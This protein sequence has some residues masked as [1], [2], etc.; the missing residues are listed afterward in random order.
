MGFGGPILDA[1]KPRLDERSEPRDWGGR[2]AFGGPI[3]GRGEAAAERA[4]RVGFGGPILGRGEAAAGRA[5]R[6][7]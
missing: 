7:P 6:A 4:K 3:L 2:L 5:K 1:A